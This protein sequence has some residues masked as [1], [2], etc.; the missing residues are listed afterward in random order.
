VSAW[1]T[2][3]RSASSSEREPAR[4]ER[5]AARWLARYLEEEPSVE[6]E[7]LRLTAEL[8]TG[9][10]GRNAVVAVQGLR[11]LFALRGRDN[12][13]HVISL[14]MEEL[15]TGCTTSAIAV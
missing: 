1:K 6:L 5:A 12:L 15:P 9:L 3:S 13:I 10:R 7:E 4:F 14:F 2:R 11:E 8:L